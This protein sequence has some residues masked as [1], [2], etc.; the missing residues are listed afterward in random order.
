M[1]IIQCYMPI[2]R[3]VAQSRLWIRQL[4]MATL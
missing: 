4:E 1:D 2:E 3:K